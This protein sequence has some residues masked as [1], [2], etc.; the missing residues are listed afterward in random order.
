VSQPEAALSKRIIT[1]LE[2]RYSGCYLV[3]I[4]GSPWQRKGLPDIVGCILG[5]YVGLETKMPGKEPTPIQAHTLDLI[6]QA[7]GIA[8]VVRSETDAFDVVLR[9][10]NEPCMADRGRPTPRP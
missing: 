9:G 4:H 8:G 3:K 1:A 5:R 10:L 6:R 2:Q 7:G